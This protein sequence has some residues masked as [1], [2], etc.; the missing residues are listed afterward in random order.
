MIKNIINNKVYIGQ[1][2]VGFRKRYKIRKN[3]PLNYGYYKYQKREDKHCNKHILSSMEKYGW[4]NF[5][6]YEQIDII[7]KHKYSQ[8]ELDC[9]ECYWI[10]YYQSNNKKYGYNKNEGGSGGGRLNSQ[11]QSVV[12]LNEERVFP[13]LA[14]ASEYVNIKDY[15]S[16]TDCCNGIQKY[17]GKINGEFAVWC[18]Y[19]EYI[20]LTKDEIQDKLNKSNDTRKNRKSKRKVLCINDNLKFNSLR[21]CASYYGVN[22]GRISE[23][24]KGDKDFILIDDKEYRFTYI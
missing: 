24:C 22:H 4:E 20:N 13:S 5:I 2:I 6:I 18:H 12:L 11:C 16:I 23:C 3:E 8:Q 10:Y 19:D 14:L 21:K 1:T 17:A 9:R 7:Y 15:D